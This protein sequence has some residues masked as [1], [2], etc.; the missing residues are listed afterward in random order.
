MKQKNENSKKILTILHTFCLYNN[1]KPSL[2]IILSENFSRLFKEKKLCTRAQI[3]HF[4][5]DYFLFE[6]FR[7]H[8]EYSVLIFSFLP[9]TFEF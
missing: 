9:N 4:S 2:K 5:E 1:M 6:H 7:H 3:I 8:L